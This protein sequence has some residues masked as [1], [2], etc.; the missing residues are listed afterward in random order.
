MMMDVKTIVNFLTTEEGKEM[1]EDFLTKVHEK[2][3]EVEGMEEY[4]DLI[5]KKVVIVKNEKIHHYHDIGSIGEVEA[6]RTT[7]GSRM[8]LNFVV[9]VNGLRQSVAVDEVVPVKER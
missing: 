5:G 6:I 9:N 1:L 8:I 4:K 3:L 7:Y 2:A